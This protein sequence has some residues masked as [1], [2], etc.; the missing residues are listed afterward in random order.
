MAD[1]NSATLE[2]SWD[3]ATWVD[4]SGSLLGLSGFSLSEVFDTFTITGGGTT[5]GVGK[6]GYRT[7]TSSFPIDEN[8]VTRTQLIGVGGASLY[9]RYRRTG[10]GSGKPQR[11][12]S[13]PAS[14][15]LESEPEGRRRFTVNIDNNGVVSRETQ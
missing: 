14:V 10:A 13:G 7:G 9:L 4:I 2:V 5:Q 1:F 12:W 8:D 3:N 11:V 15:T 6:T